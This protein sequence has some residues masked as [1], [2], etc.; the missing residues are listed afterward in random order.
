MEA[1]RAAGGVFLERPAI[2]TAA[3]VLAAKAAARPA[4]GTVIGN[5][6]IGRQIGAGGM[7]VVY[8][9]TDRRLHRRAAHKLLTQPAAVEAAER[10]NRFQQEARAVSLLNHPNIVSI[11]DADFDQG[12][13]YIA[14]EL[15]E[16]RTL[17]K[18]MADERR[19]LDNKKI[20][21][22]IAQAAFALG[23]AHDAGIA[24]RDIKPENLM[25]RPDGFV[26]VLDF[27]LA[28]L[29]DPSSGSVPQFSGFLTRPGH[30]A[31]TIHYLS[32]EQV[33]GRPLDGRSD[34]FSLG[35]VAYELVTGVRPFEGPTIGSKTISIR[36]C[37]AFA[38]CPKVSP[39]QIEGHGPYSG[40]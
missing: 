34:L 26:K 25:V 22:W 40:L 37:S 33:T 35:V 8:E 27:G 24:H 14:M 7:G 13:Y 16:G 23:A 5:Y 29:R 19:T 17:R 28:K 38:D 30:A 15:V 10:I 36:K 6:R 11:Y 18:V 12:Y 20:L 21:D 1:D 3:E 9:A 4:S 32:P 39:I 31:G 2:E